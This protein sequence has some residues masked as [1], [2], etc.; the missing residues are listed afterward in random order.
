MFLFNN[1]N[2]LIE[3]GEKILNNKIRT[4]VLSIINGVPKKFMVFE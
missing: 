2:E 1:N 3:L 4:N